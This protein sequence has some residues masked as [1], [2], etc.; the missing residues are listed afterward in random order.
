MLTVACVKTILLWIFPTASKISPVIIICFI[1]TTL[2]NE[3]YSYRFMRVDDDSTFANSSDVTNLLVDDFR[4]SMEN[5]GR[6]ASC[7]NEKNE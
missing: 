2:N 5:T 6:Y 3:K 4:T 1:L 7:L